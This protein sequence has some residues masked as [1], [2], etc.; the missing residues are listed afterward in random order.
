LKRFGLSKRDNPEERPEMGPRP[1]WAARGGHRTQGHP[2]D[3]ITS[4]V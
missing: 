4:P 2:P 3:R 1:G